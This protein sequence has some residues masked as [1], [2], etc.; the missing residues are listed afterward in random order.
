MKKIIAGIFFSFVFSIASIV[1]ALP[2]N[3]EVEFDGTSHRVVPPSLDPLSTAIN[4][5]DTV[6]YNYH[7]TGDDYFEV[8]NV[9]PFWPWIWL[10]I[11]N[12]TEREFTM[13]YSILNNGEVVSAVDRIDLALEIP[14]VSAPQASTSSDRI[15]NFPPF[16]LTNGTIFDQIVFDISGIGSG[17]PFSFS[18][19]QPTELDNVVIGE[20]DADDWVRY[21]FAD[22]GGGVV[23]PPVD[24][25]G[26]V[27]P[28]SP[29]PVPEPTTVLLF[30]VGLASLAGVNR[31]RNK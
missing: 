31:R 16:R 10:P 13:G 5:V 14:A 20:P 3:F 12:P 30:G 7:T 28:P 18:S 15:I 9:A 19:Y 4:S 17:N 6:T 22:D 26:V 24:D 27:S 8:V 23:S 29:N 1:Y 25:G 11:D 2:Y 21:V